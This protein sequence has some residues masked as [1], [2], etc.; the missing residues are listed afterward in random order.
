MYDAVMEHCVMCLD[1]AW[2]GWCL[3]VPVCKRCSTVVCTWCGIGV[4]VQCG[5]VQIRCVQ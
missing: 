4:F 3:V 2:S 1:G 5:V